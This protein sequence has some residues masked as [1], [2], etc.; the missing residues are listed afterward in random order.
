MHLQRTQPRVGR[1]IFSSFYILVHNFVKI[2]FCQRFFKEK[3]ENV[4][5]NSIDKT[6]G[7]LIHATNQIALY[8]TVQKLNQWIKSNLNDETFYEEI[9][10]K[11]CK[12][13][14]DT[15]YCL[16]FSEKETFSN[17]ATNKIFQSNYQMLFEIFNYL[18]VLQKDLMKESAESSQ[19][20]LDLFSTLERIKTYLEENVNP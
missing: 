7:P 10:L 16:Q 11:L 17:E 3:I 2:K 20:E 8:K 1:F 14:N 4:I 6:A 13:K 5:L 19:L 9:R 12:K 15:T 18:K